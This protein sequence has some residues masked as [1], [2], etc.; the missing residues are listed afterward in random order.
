MATVKERPRLGGRSARIQAS[1]HEA[2]E[3]LSA[4]MDRSELAIPAIAARAGVTPSTIY[5]RWG[6]LGDLLADVAVKRLRPMADPLDTGSART[7]LQAWTEQF[8]EEMSSEVGRAMIRDVFSSPVETNACQCC[9]YT[10][11][12]L[13]TIADRTAGRG[14][15]GFDVDEV[16]DHVVAPIM[17]R[18]L[19][20]GRPM[21]MDYC[22]ALIDRV[23]PGCE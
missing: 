9:A 3:Q 21:D 8:M 1:V 22:D 6:S 5:R 15:A 17:Y 12:Q 14:E 19:F 10:Y 20:S 11:E 7:D 23:M 2:V 13:Q 18:I 4:E 16:V